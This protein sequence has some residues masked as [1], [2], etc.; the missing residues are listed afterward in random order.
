MTIMRSVLSLWIGSLAVASAQELF[1]NMG[2]NHCKGDNQS[3][4]KQEKLRDLTAAECR[5]KCATNAVEGR[6][7]WGYKAYPDGRCM[8]YFQPVTELRE[9]G[10][11]GDPEELHCYR[12]SDCK[13]VFGGTAVHD[14]CGVCD[15]DNTSCAD[16]CGVP[17]GDNTKCADCEGVPNGT[18]FFDACGECGGD[19]SSCQITTFD[20]IAEI[21]GASPSMCKSCKGRTVLNDGNASCKLNFKRVKK[22][23]LWK[24]DEEMCRRMKGCH[25]HVKTKKGW[26]TKNC[27]GRAELES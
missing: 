6:Y 22:C 16:E 17:N 18:T 24:K 20:D 15:G 8:Y 2:D 26:V 21:C 12:K 4:L 19:D 10:E 25:W 9:G 7:C 3:K 1:E 14:K 5:E 27:K 11:F 23:K 13:G